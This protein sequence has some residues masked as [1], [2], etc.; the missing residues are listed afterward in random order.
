MVLVE[1]RPIAI[2]STKALAVYVPR[3]LQVLVRRVLGYLSIH[4]YI[5]WA[6]PWG[7]CI[8]VYST[9]GAVHMQVTSATWWHWQCYCWQHCIWEVECAPGDNLEP[10]LRQLLHC[11]AQAREYWAS[12][13]IGNKT[14]LKNLMVPI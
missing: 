4:G 11:L 7:S 9:W 6:V 12:L 1:R 2:M 5:F 3:E 14:C 13:Y 8:Y 10:A